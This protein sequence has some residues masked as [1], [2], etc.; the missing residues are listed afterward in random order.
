M[1]KKSLWERRMDELWAER[2]KKKPIWVEKGEKLTYP[3]RKTA[4]KNWIEE[5]ITF[6]GGSAVIENALEVMECVD[7]GNFEEAKKIN[8]KQ[9]EG[10]ALNYSKKGPDFYDF[11]CPNQNEKVKQVVAKIREE[12]ARFDKEL[13]DG[14]GKE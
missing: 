9:V 4:W 11:V 1:K 2:L 5:M 3:Q 7:K 10:I 12:N 8:K 14:K 13:K 6:S